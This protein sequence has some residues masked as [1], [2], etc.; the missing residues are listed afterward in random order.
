MKAIVFEDETRAANHLERLL[1]RVAP[2]ISVL[3]KLESVR[4]AVKY[5]QNNPEPELIFSDIQLAD[6]LSFE[7]YKQ[8]EVSCPIIFTTA[9]DHYAIEAFKTN[10]IDYLLKPVEEERLR[11]AIDKAK[12][13]SP[14]LV[15]EKLLAMNRPVAEKAYKSRFMVKVGDKIKSVP[16]EEILVF[17]SQEKASFIRTTDTHTYCIDYALDQLEPMLDPEKYFRIN[18]KYIVAIDAC[19]NILAWTNSRLRLKIEGIDDSDII[20]ARERVVEFKSW[21]DR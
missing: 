5:L 9:Y 15:L 16:V 13:F 1:A 20:V 17:Y 2:E 19:T 3:A 7:I 11:Q 8:V 10:G 21:L 18:R 4:D 6:G 14:G 12:H